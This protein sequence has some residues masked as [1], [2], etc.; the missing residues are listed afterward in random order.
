MVTSDQKWTC[1][2]P[3]PARI[4]TLMLLRGVWPARPG[5]ASAAGFGRAG[6]GDGPSGAGGNLLCGLPEQGRRA[7]LREDGGGDRE[8]VGTASFPIDLLPGTVAS[9][10][11][12][13]PQLWGTGGVGASLA[14]GL[15]GR[16]GLADRWL[17]GLAVGVCHSPGHGVRHRA[18][19]RLRGSLRHPGRG[20][21]GGHRRGWLGGLPALPAR[22]APDLP[23][24]SAA[25]LPGDDRDLLGC[26]AELSPACQHA[27]A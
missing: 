23:C 3:F 27:P 16:D 10:T 7:V 13:R 19:A 9:G 12:G 22:T 17:A 14:G 26:G 24:P 2:V 4:G 6:G 5:S 25:T 8:D 15:S 20:L 21:L 18:R 1:G 11:Q